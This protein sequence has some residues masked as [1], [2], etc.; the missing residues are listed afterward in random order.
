MPAS[1]LVAPLR[2]ASFFTAGGTP[3]PPGNTGRSYPSP[4]GEKTKIILIE[5][6]E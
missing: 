1:S 3:L 2:L 4:M 6:N 5:E